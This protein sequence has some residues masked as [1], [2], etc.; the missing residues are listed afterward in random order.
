MQLSKF[1]PAVLDRLLEERKV[2]VLRFTTAIA[3]TLPWH[4]RRCRRRRALSVAAAAAAATL[5][6]ASTP[7]VVDAPAA[8][9]HHRCIGHRA[10]PPAEDHADKKIR[11]TLVRR[12]SWC[13]QRSGGCSRRTA[14]ARRFGAP[15]IAVAA[16]W[17]LARKDD[18]VKAV[19]KLGGIVVWPL[20]LLTDR[21]SGST[22]SAIR[23]CRR[24]VSPTASASRRRSHRPRSSTTASRKVLS[25]RTSSTFRPSCS[26]RCSSRSPHD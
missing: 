15:A 1:S 13:L 8:A 4:C 6:P 2:S 24:R 20:A 7:G 23:R 11:H 17:W 14:A 16:G 21:S 26:T 12:F 3:W 5:A 22:P 19:N 9:A 10:H 25:G 18:P